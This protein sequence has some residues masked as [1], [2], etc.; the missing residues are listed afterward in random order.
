M[1]VHSVNRLRPHQD[2]ISGSSTHRRQREVSGVQRPLILP[3][4]SDK[5][6]QRRTVRAI[7]HLP[8]GYLELFALSGDHP[9][10]RWHRRQ[11]CLMDLFLR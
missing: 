5:L 8:C 7:S 3:P 9:R 11:K 10:A 4:L 2:I 6:L 1:S